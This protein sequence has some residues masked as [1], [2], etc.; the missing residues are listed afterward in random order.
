MSTEIENDSDE[1][2]TCRVI[3]QIVDAN[4]RVVASAPAK[5]MTVGAWA[6]SRFESQ[7][8]LSKPLL[9]SIE[10]PSLY[11]AITTIESNGIVTDREE[12]TFGIRTDPV[13]RGQRILPQ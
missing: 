5:R 9:W 6:N 2:R 11:R 8:R 12:T 7:T 1:D 10:Q 3:S 4:G 13:R